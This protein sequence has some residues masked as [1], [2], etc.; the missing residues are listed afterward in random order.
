MS[1][2]VKASAIA[3]SAAVCMLLAP[4]ATASAG[5]SHAPV[6]VT[7]KKL[8]G[9]LLLP[10]RFQPG[11]STIFAGNSGGKL[12]HGAVFHI[13]SMKCVNFWNFIGNVKGFGE[14]AF[15]TES[16][17]SKS[18]KAPILE[19]FSQS[20]YQS[21]SHHAATVLNGQISARYK[22]CKS[23]SF[24]DGNGG[25]IH[26]TVHARK[27][28]RVGGHPS[29]LLTQYLTDTKIKGA[30]VVTKQLWTIAGTNVYM[31]ESHLLNV[32]SPKPTLSSLVLKL[33]AR[34]R[35]LT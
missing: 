8:K 25:T 14:T 7:G 4:A 18:G 5:V 2:R 13:P 22:S 32:T 33:I 34:V 17:T 6:Q 16:A 19:I 23:V 35:A 24:S 31:M 10:S 1:F 28:E 15:A 26:E 27:A 30:R 29:L 11:Y 20:V 3:V 9:A 12:E 21:A